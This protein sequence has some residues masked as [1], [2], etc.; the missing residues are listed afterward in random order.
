MKQ[1]TLI[2]SLALIASLA[3]AQ[4]THLSL[5]LSKAPAEKVGVKAL[6]G[7]DLHVSVNGNP[8]TG[9]RWQH[10]MEISNAPGVK[11]LE[12]TYVSNND[13]VNG[14]RLSGV[15]GVFK[16][17]YGFETAGPKSIELVYAQPWTVNKFQNANGA[18]D[19][20]NFFAQNDGT[21]QRKT[22]MVQALQPAFL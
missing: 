9:Y 20:D 17:T 22:V 5:D 19:W 16:F 2:L 15:G 18:I 7:D 14:E 21:Y 4:N 1:Q 13:L 11:I 6:V 10:A 12:Q 3:V 8:T